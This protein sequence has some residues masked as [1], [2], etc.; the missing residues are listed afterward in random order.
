MYLS[1]TLHV[2]YCLADR[3]ITASW[4]FR[5]DTFMKNNELHATLILTVIYSLKDRYAETRA[6]PPIDKSQDWFL[7]SGEEE[8]GFTILEFSRNLT[9]C[10][11]K[12]LEIKVL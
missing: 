2:K 7:I 10:D 8:N 12:D 5:R 3:P 4:L 11:T 1:L 6:R 9:T